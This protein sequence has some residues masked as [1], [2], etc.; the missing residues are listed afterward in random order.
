LHIGCM[1]NH[2]EIVELLLSAPTIDINAKTLE[3]TT[4]LYLA[5]LK[6]SY[7]I[8]KK[9]L[10]HNADVFIADNDGVTPLHISAQHVHADLTRVILTANPDLNA[11]KMIMK[12]M[13]LTI[14]NNFNHDSKVISPFEFYYSTKR[15]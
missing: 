1:Q 11:G 9:L 3:G 7:D 4:P 5:V 2:V 12:M 6:G 14:L 13:M 10:E 15:W 8:A